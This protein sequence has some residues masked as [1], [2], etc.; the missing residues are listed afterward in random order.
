MFEILMHPIVQ[1]LLMI[2][3]IQSR[4]NRCAE[5]SLLN[6][7]RNEVSKKERP[8]SQPQGHVT[9]DTVELPWLRWQT[10]NPSGSSEELM[11]RCFRK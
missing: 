6:R 11:L 2:D 7:T 9:M 3:V 5:K 4:F 8:Q 1:S 10:M